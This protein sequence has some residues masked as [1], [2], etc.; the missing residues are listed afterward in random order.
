MKRRKT[1]WKYETWNGG[2]ARHLDRVTIGKKIARNYK[3]GA[4]PQDQSLELEDQMFCLIL[5]QLTVAKSLNG[6]RRH[7]T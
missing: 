2:A 7:D 6:A 5:D 1:V 4:A 3:Q